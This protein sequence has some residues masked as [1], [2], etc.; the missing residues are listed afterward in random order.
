MAQSKFIFA[1]DLHAST[2]VFDKLLLKAIKECV[3]AVLIGGD[4]SSKAIVLLRQQPDGS[5]LS[6]GAN[7]DRRVQAGE[8]LEL[9][10]ADIHAMGRHPIR[11]SEDEFL[12]LTQNPDLK[13]PLAD[14]ADCY[15]LRH[16]LWLAERRLRPKGI[17]F[18]IISGNDDPWQFDDLVA[19]S[20]FAENPEKKM[21]V[22]EGGHEVVGESTAPKNPY[23]NSPR[24]LD[25]SKIET[26]IRERISA[27]QSMSTA[28]FLFHS[29][30]RDSALDA[31]P[32]LDKNLRIKTSGGEA[33][34]TGIGSIAVRKA[35]ASRQPLLGLHG[36]VHESPSHDMIGRTLCLNPGSHYNTGML[37]A[38][39]IT[40][41]GDRV[42]S[43]RPVLG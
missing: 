42:V 33:C 16:W 27:I 26:R 40:V 10:E 32:A 7:T 34:I 17:R 41:D 39:L 22:L 6:Y 23:W 3:G 13:K 30:P 1:T 36:H 5:Y 29:P 12:Q 14:A 25:E 11:V 15:L 20:T 28:I 21:C 8:D 18:L 19:E 43:Y 4:L 2:L 38:F 37:S 9:F 31:A 24:D 35:I